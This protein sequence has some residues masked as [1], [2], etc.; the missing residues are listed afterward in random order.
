M[1]MKE[2]RGEMPTMETF[3]F[4][5][6]NIA[7]FVLMLFY[8][9]NNLSEDRLV[10]QRLAK[11]IGLILDNGEANTTFFVDISE[12]AKVAKD[13][14]YTGDIFFLNKSSGEIK[15]QLSRKSGYLFNYFSDYNITYSITDRD[16][17]K[18]LFLVLG[19]K[20]G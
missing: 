1:V 4:I 6:L 3:I 8:I 20:N 11:Q 16:A 12:G 14:E 10:E 13:N 2:K 9:S 15:F 18:Y 17:Q 7:F 5:V 19:E